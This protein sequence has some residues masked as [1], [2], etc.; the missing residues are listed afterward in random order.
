MGFLNVLE[1]VIVALKTRQQNNTKPL[2]FIKK[3][4]VLGQL[5][6]FLLLNSGKVS[7][8]TSVKSFSF[9]Y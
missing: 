8:I 6:N 3:L 5:D 7:R 1:V 2:K 4:P 9:C